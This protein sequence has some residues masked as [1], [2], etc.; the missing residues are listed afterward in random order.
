MS[1]IVD[2][3]RPDKPTTEDEI[4]KLHSEAFRDLEGHIGDCVTMSS[5][6]SERMANIRCDDERLAFAVFHTH[7]M[8]LNL[9]KYYKAAWEGGDALTRRLITS[10]AKTTRELEE[11]Y[12]SRLAEDSH[13]AP[14]PIAPDTGRCELMDI[15]DGSG[16][17]HSQ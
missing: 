16:T 7:E 14:A 12:R 2:F 15:L 6:A 4:D 11:A 5:F 17:E 8:L 1:N 10:P 3:S 9:Q 13:E